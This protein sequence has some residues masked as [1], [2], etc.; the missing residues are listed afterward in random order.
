MTD[1]TQKKPTTT[2]MKRAAFEQT[3]EFAKLAAEAEK[4]ARDE[5][6]AR[7]RAMRLSRQQDH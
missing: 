3:T 2:E 4:K 7:L 5:K 1:T 6:T